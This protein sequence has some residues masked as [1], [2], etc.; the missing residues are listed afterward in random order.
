MMFSNYN[1]VIF[2]ICTFITYF[3]IFTKCGILV[4][5]FHRCLFSHVCIR[6]PIWSEYILILQFITL[7]R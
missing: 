5:L 7:E 2:N 3:E 1:Y 4:Y 6:I